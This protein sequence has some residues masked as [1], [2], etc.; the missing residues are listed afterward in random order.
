MNRARTPRLLAQPASLAA[1]V[2]TLVAAL[3]ATLAGCGEEEPEPVARGTLTMQIDGSKRTFDFDVVD[4]GEA[5]S[6][7]VAVDAEATWSIDVHCTADLEGALVLGGDVAE[8][9]GGP[10]IGTH[11]AA[12]VKQGTSDAMVMWVEDPPPADS[13]EAFV[14]A[15]PP[16]VVTGLIPVE[17]ELMTGESG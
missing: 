15:I 10:E 8:S 6:G 2:A 17:G 12:V 1:L 7:S 16:G 14:G 4:D 11:A 13:C 3:V 5:V 9:E